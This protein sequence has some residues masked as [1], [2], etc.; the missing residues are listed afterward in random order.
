MTQV[1]AT[2]DRL[3]D[4]AE[5]SLVWVFNSQASVY[6][7]G[8]FMGRGEWKLRDVKEVNRKS[9]T[10][11]HGKFDRVTGKQLGLRGYSASLH[12]YGQL[13][14]EDKAW[15]DQHYRRIVRR[16]EHNPTTAQLKAIFAILGMDGQNG[17]E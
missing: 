2:V 7:E 6:E 1:R 3:T 16:V 14:Y 5:G 9:I 17:P 8:V 10:T 13:D 15:R 12:A 4:A 11:I